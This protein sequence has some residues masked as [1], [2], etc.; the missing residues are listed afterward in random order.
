MS[1][2]KRMWTQLTWKLKRSKRS[3][4]IDDVIDLQITGH[5]VMSEKRYQNRVKAQFCGPTV[6]KQYLVLL[7]TTLSAMS[8]YLGSNLNTRDIYSLLL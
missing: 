2:L 6:S 7:A 5:V 8:S 3:S 4:T 1:E